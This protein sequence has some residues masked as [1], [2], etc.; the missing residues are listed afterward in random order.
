MGQHLCGLISPP[1]ISDL[2][3]FEMLIK[4]YLGLVAC[5]QSLLNRYMQKMSG[6][7]WSLGGAFPGQ[8]LDKRTIGFGLH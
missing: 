6:I 5:I 2:D 3:S 7:L 1:T 8:F 4:F